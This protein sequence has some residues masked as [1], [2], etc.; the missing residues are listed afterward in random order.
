MEAKCKL[1][2]KSPGRGKS[3]CKGPEAEKCSACFKH[4]KRARQLEHSE[5]GRHRI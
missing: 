3:R 5:K 1:I 2:L 4:E